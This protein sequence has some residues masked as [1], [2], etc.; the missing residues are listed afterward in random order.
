MEGGLDA[1]ELYEQ[2]FVAWTEQQAA[3]ESANVLD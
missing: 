2:D 1:S 3:A